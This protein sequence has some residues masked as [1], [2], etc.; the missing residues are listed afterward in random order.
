MNRT[1]KIDPKPLFK[2]SPYLYMQFMEPLGT[3]DTSVD[4]AWDFVHNRWRP[5]LME[6]VQYLKPTMVRW[7]GCFASYYR[8]KEAVG[9]FEERKPML[10]LAW[11]GL[12]SN[13]VG[14]KEI[15]SFC[16]E[17]ASEPLLVVN[18]ESDGRMNWA[19]PA[20]GMDRLGTKEEAAEWVDYCNNPDNPLRRSHGDSEPYQVKY[21]QIGNETSYDPNGFDRDTAARKTSEFAKAMKKAD[22]SIK[23]IAWGD[24][25]W[26][27][28]MCEE[29]GEDI[30]YLAFHHHFDSGLKDSPL[31]GTEYRKD[32]ALTWEHLM[33][34]YRSLESKLD[35][36]REQVKPFGKKIVMTEGHFALPGRNRCEVLS[37]WAAGVS[38][39][40]CMNTQARNG[41][42]LDIA[43]MSDFFGNRWQVNS[44]M[45]P[46]PVRNYKPY[47]QPVAWV[48][49]LFRHHSGE[50]GIR[51]I[52]PSEL[53]ITASRTGNKL[54][55]HL[56]NTSMTESHEIDFEIEGMTIEGGTAYEIA[57]DPM[58]EI[59]ELIPDVFKPVEKAIE[60]KSWQIPPASVTAIELNVSKVRG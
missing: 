24:D 38:Y 39:A 31:Y 59:T 33:H 16:R 56:V 23:L 7:G 4:A 22:P 40:R 20:P 5:E 46:T 3:A 30:E 13:H 18:M 47:L 19:Y 35:S 25:G 37:S 60:G 1:I 36:M 50:D 52:G 17:V 21:W 48:A 43:T 34:A 29:A 8:W 15:I 27:A 58:L 2:L 32:P 45:I 57:S 54:F 12:Y 53:D 44:I 14:T 42:I 41:D 51:V 10:N 26:A 55:L 9:A 6:A 11:D 49:A 28:R